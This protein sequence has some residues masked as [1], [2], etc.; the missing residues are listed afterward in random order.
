MAAG[1]R[2]TIAALALL[3]ALAL[4]IFAD[5]LFGGGPRVLGHSASDLFLQYYAWRDFG[6]RELAKG[7]LALWNPHIF[8]GAPYLGGMQGA[9]LYPPNWIFLILPL[10]VA[11]N[12]SIALH[13]F[14]VAAFMF[15]WMKQ[16]GLTASA[17]FLAGTLVMFSGAFFGHI[18]AGH[19]PQLCTMSWA[20]LIFCSIDGLLRT[21]QVTCL[22]AG[23]FGVAMQV[24][25]GFPQYLLY[26][27]IIAALYT[28]LRLLSD[29]SWR[30][31]L[32]FVGIYFGGALLASVQL[33][34][35]I[36]TTHETT[37]GLR[38]PFNFAAMVAFPPENFVTLLA[39]N[40]FGEIAK[41]WGRWYLWETSLFIGVSGV[42]LSVYAAIRCDLRIKLPPLIIILVSLLLALG[43]YTPLFHFLYVWVPG[44]DRFRSVSKFIFPASL[45]II[46]LAAT[47]FDEL[48]RGKT[49]GKAFV[50]A[51]FAGAVVLGLVAW[52]AG[53]T[54][55]WPAL[56][57]AARVTGESYLFPQLYSDT[58]F[59]TRS[60]QCAAT[61]LVIAAA[62]CAVLGVILFATRY[63]ARALFGIIPL[64]V[65]E[66]LVFASSSRPTSDSS[67]IVNAEERNFLAEHPGDY[68][69]MNV[70]NPNTAM[71][72]GAQDLWGY[73]ATVMRRYAEFM[74]WTQ[75]GDPNNAMSYVKLVQFDP[76]FAMLRERYVF[77]QQ[78]GK[79]EMEEA[80]VVMPHLQLISNYR[81]LQNRDAIFDAMR[82]ETFD[83]RQKV[84]LESEPEPK[85]V[86]SNSNGIAR[87]TATTTD[88]LTIEA[89]V[90]QPSILLI[91]D[92]YAASW[93]TVSLPGSAQPHYDLLPAN[94]VLRAVPL[95]TG[96]HLLRVEYRPVAFAIGKWTSLICVVAFLAAL[97]HCSRANTSL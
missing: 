47:G 4:A 97:I 56:M 21:R 24:L 84:I 96:H 46:L 28:I 44:F 1:H 40:V 11:I 32:A 41:Y 6:F 60:Q 78:S 59:I 76:L 61:S 42:V 88:S 10:P 65:A 27:A 90:E 3:F 54:T 79:F 73:D 14:A 36:Q 38:L 19:L 58:E 68:R 80:P 17:S 26:T 75:G 71:I 85:P 49:V 53:S 25:A 33:L 57:N 43:V 52:W 70:N 13:V 15:L 5:L 9:Q 66:M 35:A 89:D 39:P 48:L 51:V 23:M 20:P 7:N 93:R 37:R 34:P 91:T 81:V 12:W 74:T 82:S 50:A 30:I 55:S 8:S 18:F 77:A 2:S 87:I 83:P 95:A 69:I 94:Y 92:A 86:Q 22:L 29:W 16:R 67:T 62:V 31:A 45:F 64:A 72:L 63:N